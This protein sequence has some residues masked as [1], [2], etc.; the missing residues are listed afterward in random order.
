MSTSSGTINN[1]RKRLPAFESFCRQQI[2]LLGLSQHREKVRTQ[3]RKAKPCLKSN[4][5][6]NFVRVLA[7]CRTACWINS[8]RHRGSRHTRLRAT[9]SVLSS[10]CVKGALGITCPSTV[11]SASGAMARKSP[12]ICL[13]FPATSLSASIAQSVCA[14]WKYRA[15][16]T[17]VGGTGGEPAPLPEAEID[18]LRSGLHLRNAEP[19]PLLT[20]GRR[21]RIRSGALAGMAGVVVRIKNCLRIVLTMDLI[22][23][24]MAVEVDGCELEPLD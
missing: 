24:S 15:F 16:S 13:C 10:T 19:H 14:S 4:P 5:N 20:V 1:A 9:R 6:S 22:M 11:R 21:A 18:A 23:S 7:R 3:A 2:T 17:I 12:W 8:L